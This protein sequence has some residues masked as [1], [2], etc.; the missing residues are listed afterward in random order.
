MDGNVKQK[1]KTLR[2]EIDNC[3]QQL[4]Q[5]LKAREV[6]AIKVR[7]LKRGNFIASYDESRE[8]QQ[9]EV[10]QS[11]NVSMFVEACMQAIV[12]RSRDLIINKRPR[13]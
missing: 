12:K 6:I 11:Q 13:M 4:I 2:C 8:Q 1:L 7:K 3:D 9:A 10:R 5:L